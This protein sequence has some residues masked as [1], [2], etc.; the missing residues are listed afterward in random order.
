[1]PKRNGSQIII[2]ALIDAGIDTV[3]G[4]PGG[5]IMPFFDVLMDAPLAHVLTRHEQMAVHAADAY[6]RSSGRLGVCVTTSG[7][8]AT[9]MATGIGTAQMDSAP[10]L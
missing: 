3:F 9:N 1:M 5:Q 6:A 7:P 8:G 10:V 2:D 4:Y